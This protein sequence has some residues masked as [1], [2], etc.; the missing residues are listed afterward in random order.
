M[1]FGEER[2][3]VPEVMDIADLHDHETARSEAPLS[4]EAIAV[5]VGALVSGAWYAAEITGNAVQKATEKVRDRITD[6]RQR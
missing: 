4:V 1:S 3:P 6:L 5:V 2:L